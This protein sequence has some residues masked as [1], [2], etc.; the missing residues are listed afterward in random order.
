MSLTYGFYNS[1]DGDRKYDALQLSSI[2]DGIITDG[3][4]AN[5]GNAFRPYPTGGRVIAVGTGRA[6]FNHTWTLNDTSYNITMPEADPL[7]SR[8]DAIVIEVNSNAL[9]RRNSI[10]VISGEP[11][12]A[13]KYPMMTHTTE[14]HQYPIAYIFRKEASTEITETDITHTVGFDA[15][16]YVIAPTI[17][18]SVEQLVAKMTAEWNSRSAGQTSEFRAWID[19]LKELS[20]DNQQAAFMQALI[21]MNELAAQLNSLKS[22]GEILEVLSDHW[23]DPILTKKG[24]QLGVGAR[25]VRAGELDGMNTTVN[26]YNGTITE[27]RREVFTPE[28]FE[29]NQARIAYK[30]S[31]YRGKN[32]GSTFT[33]QQNTSLKN[34]EYFNFCVGDYWE[35]ASASYK[36]VIVDICAWPNYASPHMVI[37][38]SAPI[39]TSSVAWGNNEAFPNSSLVPALNELAAIPEAFFGAENIMTKSTRHIDNNTSVEVQSKMC[40]PFQAQVLGYN[41]LP[42]PS[43]SSASLVRGNAFEQ[44]GLFKNARF[45]YPQS[46]RIMF[47]D[48]LNGN[49]WGGIQNGDLLARSKAETASLIPYFTLI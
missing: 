2:F 41:V 42:G 9:V 26:V 18:G 17:G 11:G 31:T 34:G 37:M 1:L 35:P 48:M 15:C 8:Y 21:S 46:T 28:A 6:W 22:T 5:Y 32:L 29:N 43:Y 19:G 7:N 45:A 40:L 12:L 20:L 10:K 38:P 13:P 3:V 47:A 49:V 30:R 23:G 36:W 39:N 4:Y 44:F 33:T 27:S 16:P 25:F 14:R 24:E